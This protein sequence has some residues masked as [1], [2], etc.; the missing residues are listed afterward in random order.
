MDAMNC[1]IYL[2]RKLGF[3]INWNKVMGATQQLVYLGI[4]IDTSVMYVKLPED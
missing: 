4:G 2:L 3:A 1:L